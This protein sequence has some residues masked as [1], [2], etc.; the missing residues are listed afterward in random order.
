MRLSEGRPFSLVT[1]RKRT[2]RG[3]LQLQGKIL[4]SAG[5]W[6]SS[7]DWWTESAK[8]EN[9][10]KNQSG[11]WDREEWDIALAHSNGSE[12]VSLVDT[13]MANDPGNR[14]ALYRIYRDLATGHWFADASYD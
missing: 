13:G 7:G 5:P 6:R 11:P 10:S 8:E 1:E 4:W 14:I 12:S 2:D 9:V 3:E